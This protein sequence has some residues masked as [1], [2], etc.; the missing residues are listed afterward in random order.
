VRYEF[1]LAIASCRIGGVDGGGRGVSRDTAGTPFGNVFHGDWI[2]VP[3]RDPRNSRY[4][5]A[6]Q[7][8]SMSTVEDF[9]TVYVVEIQGMGVAAFND[10]SLPEATQFALNSAFASDLMVLIHDGKP[11][12]DGSSE[13]FVREAFPEEQEKWR[14]SQVRAMRSGEIDNEQAMWVLF[15]VSVTDPTDEGTID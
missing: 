9:M 13:L 3:A 4:F 10:E 6:R 12:W 14:A 1:Q 5:P 2:K 7:P 15:L 8:A 11:L